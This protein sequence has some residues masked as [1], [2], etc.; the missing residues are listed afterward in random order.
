MYLKN[1]NRLP[2]LLLFCSITYQSHAWGP[3]GHRV[4]GEIAEKYLSET[5]R[6]KIEKILDGQS[7]AMAS[8]WMDD[9]RADPAYNYAHDWHWVTI[10]DG[11]SYEQTEKNPNGDII[12]AID[13]IIRALKS[14]HLTLQ[15]ESEHL[16]M[17]IYLVGD[18]HQPLHAGRGD[19]R[20]GNEIKL[21]W[22]TEKSNLHRVW[23]SDMIDHTKLSYTE[24]ANSLDRVAGDQIIAWQ[25]SSVRDWVNENIS[26]R[27]AIYEHSEMGYTYSYKNFPIVRLRL[28]QAGVRLAEM[29]NQIYG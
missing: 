20:G 28:L 10:P 15:E 14:K 2:M 12:E 1:L 7:L 23:D 21:M 26:Y 5:A 11:M 8:T 18:I 19:D 16:K 24:L 13:R 9:I 4:T 25:N 22:F 6:R 17:L 29:L 3:T 27:A